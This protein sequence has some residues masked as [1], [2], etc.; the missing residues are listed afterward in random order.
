MT[1]VSTSLS[2]S[3]L[4]LFF[5]VFFSSFFPLLWSVSQRSYLYL[6]PKSLDLPTSRIPSTL[7]LPS[8]YRSCL[9]VDFSSPSLLFIFLPLISLGTFRAFSCPPLSFQGHKRTFHLFFLPWA[10]LL[11]INF[12]LK[13]FSS[14]FPLSVLAFVLCVRLF[15]SY[16]LPFPF[17]VLFFFFHQVFFSLFPFCQNPVCVRPSSTDFKLFHFFSP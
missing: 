16:R 13:P 15:L 7:T 5:K 3:T 2:F 4:N 17:C 9:M 12:P 1:L 11:V 8:F 14:F 6:P 10:T